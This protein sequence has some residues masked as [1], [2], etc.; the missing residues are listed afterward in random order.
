VQQGGLRLASEATGIPTATISRRIKNLEQELGCRLLERSAHHFSLTD[1]GRHYFNQC[2]PLLDDLH[3]IADELDSDQHNLAG[4]LKITA[5]VN[6]TQQWLGKCFFDFMQAYPKIRLQLVLS[7]RYEN[8]VEQQFD[9]AFRVGDPRDNRWIARH[10]WNTRMVLCASPDYLQLAPAIN[11]PRDLLQQHLIVA[12][13]I[14]NWVLTHKAS[15][16][17]FSFTPQAY[18]RSSDILVALDAAAANLGITL[19]P[20]YYFYPQARPPQL[21]QPHPQLVSVLPEWRGP[22]RPVNL[23]YRDREV[24][25]ARL[26][27]FIDF[28][29]A[30]MESY[31]HAHIALEGISD[32]S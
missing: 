27:V 21:P 8:L 4:S 9:A 6:L 29:L 12:D 26:R 32:E 17:T 7:G 13:Y 25:S 10:L 31:A 5:P 20:N 22:V 18:L 15:G 2:G 19:V 3:A 11:H 23:L 24:M 28:V 30:W 1:M 16:E 14:E